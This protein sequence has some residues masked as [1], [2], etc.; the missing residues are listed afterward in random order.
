VK[1]GREKK[2]MKGPEKKR[3]ISGRSEKAGLEDHEKKDHTCRNGQL[4]PRRR[5][6]V[7]RKGLSTVGILKSM[8]SSSGDALVD[9]ICIGEVSPLGTLQRTGTPVVE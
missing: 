7:Q 6:Y 8:E 2:G 4:C 1:R 9:H 5:R 3:H